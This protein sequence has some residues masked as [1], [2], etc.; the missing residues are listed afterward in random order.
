MDSQPTREISVHGATIQIANGHYWDYKD[1]ENSRIDIETVAHALANT[2]RFTGHCVEFYSVA[3]HCVL[4]SYIVPKQHAL[5]AL[6][7]E[8]EEPVTGDL[9]KPWKLLLDEMTGGDLGRF[10]KE[11]ERPVLVRVFGLDPSAKPSSIKPADY[12]MLATER[13]DL[14]PKQRAVRWDARHR[15][16]A[17]EPIPAEHW[18]ELGGVVP[19]ERRIRPWVPEQA[20]RAF[21]QRYDEL[22]F[23]GHE[24]FVEQEGTLAWSMAR[25]G[26]PA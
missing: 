7:H 25:A 13:R 15:A 10:V 4:M 6:G 17:W 26:V 11:Q 20:K 1:P 19:L 22:V 2:C 23:G 9:N 5:W 8:A 16:C 14:M 21:L 18:T 3:Q 24:E 12:R